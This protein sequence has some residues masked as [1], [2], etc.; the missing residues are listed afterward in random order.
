MAHSSS[1]S[2]E[3]LPTRFRNIA[4][5]TRYQTI[6]ATKNK[7]EEQGFFL[8]DHLEN[9]G[10]VPLI[11][12]R[13]SDLG[14]LRLDRQAAQANLNWV[15]EFYAHNPKGNDAAYVRGRRVPANSA[16]INTLLDLLEDLPNIYAL[17]DALEDEVLNLIKGQLCLPNTT[18]N[19]K[20]KNP[21]TI[22]RPH[23]LPKAKLWNTFVKR[24]L[25]STF[26]NQ[27]VGRTWLVLFNAIISGFRF[28][29]GEVIARELSD[30][31]QNDKGILAFP[32]IIS[33]RSSQPPI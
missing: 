4:A 33:A 1:S 7:W 17:K 20:G 30:A 13:L 16:T 23:L 6:V 11:Y 25:M 21:G 32:C 15:W 8:D 26:H 27:T 2:A 24:N 10:F 5:M 3:G 22:S 19:I 29:I 12:K 18:W 14:R 9:Y 31:C 28:N